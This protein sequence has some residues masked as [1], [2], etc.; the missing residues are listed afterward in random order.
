MRTANRAEATPQPNLA[1]GRKP[2]QKRSQARVTALLDA[3]DRAMGALRKRHP[4][5]LL[6]VAL[7]AWLPVL[8]F[9]VLLTWT[10]GVWAL[11]VL[12]SLPTIALTV[13]VALRGIRRTWTPVWAVGTGTPATV[14]LFGTGLTTTEPAAMRAQWPISILPRILAPAPISTP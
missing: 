10:S 3:A 1:T 2:S 6:V 9:L 11:V 7:G 4:R 14:T 8:V 5:V 12:V 13:T